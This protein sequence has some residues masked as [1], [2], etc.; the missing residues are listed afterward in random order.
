MLE[1][2]KI[3]LVRTVLRRNSSPVFCA[4]LPQAETIE[5]GGWSEP[6]GFHLVVLPFADDLRTAPIEEE[7]RASESA[8]DSA[9]AWIEK[10]SIKNGIYAPDSYPNPGEFNSPDDILTVLEC[11]NFEA[12]AYH[13]VQ[14]QAS[15]F[16]EEFDAESFEDLTRPK[17]DMIHKRAGAL[18]KEWKKAVAK[19][20]NFA[21]VIATGRKRK[22]D[23]SVDEIEVRSK[24]ELRQL[25][26]G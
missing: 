26:S 22:A 23:I 18:L 17:Y 5:E 21:N 13:N 11:F 20:E 3:G 1:K 9:R 2:G 10:L 7:L 25:A 19:D 8:K 16:R 4:L 15:A 24:Y 6:A 12:L 14:L